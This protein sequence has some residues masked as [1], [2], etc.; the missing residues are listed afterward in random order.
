[1]KYTI[2]KQFGEGQNEFDSIIEITGLK[3]EL[4][5]NSLLDHLENTKKVLKEQIGQMQANDILMSKAVEE[6]PVLKDIPKDKEGI[7]FSY[8]SKK[9][10]NYQSENLIKTCQETIKTYE[11]HIKNIEE[12]TG[13]KC[14]S[15]QSILNKNINIGNA[16]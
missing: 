16:R 14:I 15:V 4:T 3:T 2:K 1:M 7:A 12:Q 13:I 8:L 9:S 5:I 11:E 6:V 10:A